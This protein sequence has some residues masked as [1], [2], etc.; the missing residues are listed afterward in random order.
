M[1]EGMALST[2]EAEVRSIASALAQAYPTQDHGINMGAITL[3]ESIVGNVRQ[4]LLI[5]WVAVAFMLAV[6]CANV[7]NLLLTHAAG[8]Q[9]EFALRRSLGATNSRLIRQLLTESVTLAALGGALGLAMAAWTLPSIV[10]QLPGSFPRLRGIGID[11]QALWFPFAISMFTGLLFGLAPAIG[12]TR[13]QLAQSLRD[14]ERSGRGVAHRRLGRLLVIG[15][16]A[17]VLVLLVGAGLV[18]RSLIRL[19]HV[20]PGFHTRGVVA[21][22]MFLPSTRYPNAAAQRTFY[23]QVADQVASLPGVQAA[24]FAQPLPF[25]PVDI[26][27]DTGFRIASHPDPSPDQVPPALAALPRPTYWPAPWT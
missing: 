2:A 17:A 6:G 15:E 11:S 10:A 22:Q 14:G 3:Q 25:G 16:V 13:R 9:R 7:A 27:T 4:L 23:R 12:S 18:V 21:W 8:R 19:S 5:L 20:D 24:G 26:L 1:K